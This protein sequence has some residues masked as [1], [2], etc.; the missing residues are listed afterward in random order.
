M[1]PTSGQA[2]RATVSRAY[3][4][5]RH[6]QIHYRIAGAHGSR[7]P[8]LLLHPS[9]LNG[10]IYENLM[11]DMGRD[12]LVVAPDTPGFGMSDPPPSPPEISDYAAVMLDFVGELGLGLVDVMGYHTGSLT[13]VEMSR[14]NP[15]VV[16]KIVMISATCFTPQETAD[17]RAKY[18]PK[19]ADERPTD[20][21]KRW[22]WFKRDFWRMENSEHRQLNLFLDGQRN[23]DWSAWGHRAAFNYD[24]A[25]ALQESA[26]PILLLNPEDD[27]WA[28]TP[29][30]APL[31]KNGRVHDLPGWTHGFLDAETAKVGMLLREYLDQ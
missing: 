28:Y 30:A 7:G 12:R 2:S 27:L 21:A 16:R 25:K 29:R 19:T 20:I 24:I 8:L 14:Q 1:A 17:F 18:V 11:A 5:S 10:S 15:D 6:G 3:A 4:K 23:P 13:A 22:P 9:P 31:L 26:H